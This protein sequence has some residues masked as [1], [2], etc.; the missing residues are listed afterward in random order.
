MVAKKKK[1]KKLKK[2]KIK[3]KSNLF[4]SK[5]RRTLLWLL[6]FFCKKND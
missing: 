1:N 6:D 2:N 3:I 5:S 4:D